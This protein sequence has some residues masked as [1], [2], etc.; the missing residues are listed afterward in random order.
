MDRNNRYVSRK[1]PYGTETSNALVGPELGPSAL[2][3]R[4]PGPRARPRSLIGRHPR[5]RTPDIRD[6]AAPLYRDRMAL[7]VKALAVRMDYGLQPRFDTQLFQE[8]GDMT[9]HGTFG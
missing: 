5:R 8:R 6:S 3:R 7:S 9:L 4:Y 1:G 2:S